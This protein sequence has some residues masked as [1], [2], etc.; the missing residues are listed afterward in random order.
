M[1]E[2]L[3]L[4]AQLFLYQL[5][6]FLCIRKIVVN[7]LFLWQLI[8]R[9]Y[10]QSELFNGRW[11]GACAN[12]NNNNM[13]LV[14]GFVLEK[15][16]FERMWIK[17]WLKTRYNPLGL[18]CSQSFAFSRRSSHEY[19]YPTYSPPIWSLSYFPCKFMQ[20]LSNSSLF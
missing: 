15:V 10:W 9:K 14:P 17:F 20:F 6:T 7:I 11:W 18:R 19:H 1:T 2:A 4:F 8:I 12:K 3:Y 16:R 13:T 5:G